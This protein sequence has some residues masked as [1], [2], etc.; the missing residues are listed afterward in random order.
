VDALVQDIR[1]GIRQLLHQRGSTAVA[2]L[3]LA[4]GIGVSTALFS[5]VDAT[6]LRPLP[7]PHPEQL[8]QVYVEEIL[9]D[10][11]QFVASSSLADM[12]ALEQATDVLSATAAVGQAFGGSITE[13]DEPERVWVRLFTESYQSMH[14]VVPLLGRDFTLDDTRYGAPAVIL[15]GYGFWQNRFAGRADIVGQT[16]RIDGSIATIIGVL[17]PSFQTDAPIVQAMQIPP[18]EAGRRGTGRLR[19]FGRLR[20]GVTIDQAAE[21]LSAYLASN[22]LPAGSGASA[23][24]VVISRLESS[25]TASRTT[26]AVV[27]SAVALILLIACV[28]VAGLL[29]VRGSGRHAELAVRASLGASRTRLV[30]QLLTESVLLAIAGAVVGIML[31][32]LGL[33]TIVASLPLAMPVD[34]P[35]SLNNSVLLATAALLV[36]TVLVFGLFPALQLSRFRLTSSLALGG[37]LARTSLSRHGRRTL[38]AAEVAL[39]TVLVIGAG[40][41]LRSFARM[42]S[43]DLGFDP[44]QLVTMEVMPLDPTPA[45]RATYYSTLLRQVRGIAGVQSAGIV[46]NFALM[47]GTAYARIA[48]SGDPVPSTVFGMSAGYLEALG[49]RLREGHLPADADFASGFRGVVL[50][51]SAA[52]A[53]FDGSPA[54]GRQITRV[55]KDVRPWVVLGIIDDIRHGGPLNARDEHSPQVF[56]PLDPASRLANQT[57]VLALRYRG[58]A[59]GLADRLRQAARS[60]GPRVLVERIATA[61]D[62]FALAT[63]TPRRRTLLLGL[64]GALGFVLALVGVFGMTA[65]AV[66]QRTVEIGVR[67]AFGAQPSAVVGTMLRDALIPIFVGTAIGLVGAYFTTRVIQGFLFQIAPT[68]GMTFGV[69]AMTLIAAGALAAFVPARR[70]ARV[71][72]AVALRSE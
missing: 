41:M 27:A 50:N 58:P 29:L 31:A 63:I 45:V 69:V 5:V 11:R 1:Y 62:R 37:R 59:D 70:A 71:D 42:T 67:M 14:G 12:R 21:R 65:Y 18:A 22:P 72:P 6:M 13:G 60:V 7:F 46:D 26:I 48:G 53:L 44:D 51:Q 57:L 4:L 28:N 9:P 40:L 61:N 16:I 17:P 49:A 36:P 10:G 43:V 39:A 30:Q 55:G 34:S 8:V 52:R 54:V 47:G 35:V 3:T 56:F 23:R 64:L 2:I 32:R 19:I 15:L 33:R 68:D 25:L 24:A 38:I 20:P 66:S